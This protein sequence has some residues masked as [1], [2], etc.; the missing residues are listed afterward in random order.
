M[1]W[2]GFGIGMIPLVL[3]IAI[4]FVINY[5]VSQTNA[6]VTACNSFTALLA[7]SLSPND[8]M[9]CYQAQNIGQLAVTYIP[10]G[11]NLIFIGLGIY[12]ITMV[13]SIIQWVIYGRRQPNNF[14]V[15]CSMCQHWFQPHEI[16]IHQK[17]VHG[18]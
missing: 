15:Y 7:R 6:A 14:T 16:V 11:R 13:G 2:I 9:R 18:L 4:L 1:L 10:V 8:D 5:T 17:Q 3:G 12:I